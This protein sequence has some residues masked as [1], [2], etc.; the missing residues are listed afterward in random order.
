MMLDFCDS[1]KIE[2]ILNDIFPLVIS[3]TIIHFDLSK[4]LIDRDNSC[5]IMYS[6]LFKKMGLRKENLW[7]HE[8]SDL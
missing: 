2:G 4:I 6:E 8:G 1:K 7:S 3:A 5:D